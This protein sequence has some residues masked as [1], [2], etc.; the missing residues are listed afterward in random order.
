MMVVTSVAFH[1]GVPFRATVCRGEPG[2]VARE[3]VL[4]L[5]ILI[6]CRYALMSSSPLSL[7]SGTLSV[8]LIS[9]DSSRRSALSSVPRCV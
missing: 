1:Y 2:H 6:G 4:S 3:I 9:L 8:W 7:A 5:L